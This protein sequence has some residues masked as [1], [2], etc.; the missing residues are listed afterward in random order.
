[1]Y[2]AEVVTMGMETK[3]LPWELK[4]QKGYYSKWIPVVTM[5]TKKVVTMVTKHK[6]VAMVTIGL[7]RYFN[8]PQWC[9]WCMIG[10]CPLA[11]V[12]SGEHHL[13][14][15]SIQSWVILWKTSFYFRFAFVV[16]KPWVLYPS[17]VWRK[18]FFW[19]LFW[20]GRHIISNPDFYINTIN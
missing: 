18:L 20:G 19:K 16:E 1:M 8:L 12:S 14:S 11:S 3:W 13:C 10:S 15:M 4:P 2:M 6:V 7:K 17:L 9:V 5:V